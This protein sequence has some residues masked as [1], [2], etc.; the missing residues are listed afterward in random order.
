MSCP[1]SRPATHL[2]QV[3]DNKMFTDSNNNNNQLQQNTRTTTGRAT[4]QAIECGT[5]CLPDGSQCICISICV[6]VCVCACVCEC[7]WVTLLGCSVIY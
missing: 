7:G 2:C 6:Y 3:C 4:G 1:S 5:N